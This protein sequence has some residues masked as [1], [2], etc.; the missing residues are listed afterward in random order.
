MGPNR[1]DL[2]KVLNLTGQLYR[3]PFGGLARDTLI[4]KRDGMAFPPVGVD[5]TQRT[6]RDSPVPLNTPAPVSISPDPK[7]LLAFPEA[8]HEASPH[9]VPPRLSQPVAA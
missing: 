4:R 3:K 8:Q 1:L 2:K 5:G 7:P 6:F 9:A